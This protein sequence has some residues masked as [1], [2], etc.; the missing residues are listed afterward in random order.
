MSI[1]LRSHTATTCPRHGR[2]AEGGTHC[3][4][5]IPRLVVGDLELV[6]CGLPLLALDETAV[7]D[8]G[9]GALTPRMERGVPR[10][11]VITRRFAHRRRVAA[12]GG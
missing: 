9:V 7:T 5:L 12:T 3:E 8:M 10:L 1:D 2:V 11:R 6:R 4:V